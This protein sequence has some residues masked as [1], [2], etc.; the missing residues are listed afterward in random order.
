MR[1]FIIAVAGAAAALSVSSCHSPRTVVLPQITRD[2][3]YASAM[4]ADTLYVRDSVTVE[5]LADT[6]YRTRLRTVY[7]VRSVSDTVRHV[8]RDTV[9]VPIALPAAKEAS[10]RGLTLP[11]WFVGLLALTVVCIFRLRSR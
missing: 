8:V 6:V 11:W 9:T 5:R 4:R 10:G 2:T 3:V 7:R 1:K